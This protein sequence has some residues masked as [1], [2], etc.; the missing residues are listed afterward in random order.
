MGKTQLNFLQQN[1]ESFSS[2]SLTG[3]SVSMRKLISKAFH[4]RYPIC[5]LNFCPSTQSYLW[6]CPFLLQPIASLSV[7]IPSTAEGF[8]SS[9]QAPT[10]LIPF[11]RVNFLCPS[12]F[13]HSD[14]CIKKPS[15]AKRMSLCLGILMDCPHSPG[16][17]G[18]L[19]SVQKPRHLICSFVFCFVVFASLLPFVPLS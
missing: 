12:F 4:G 16:S 18:N 6:S 19:C 7:Q 5:F 10:A 14:K 11:L 3:V 13:T 1:P 2:P 17:C 15:N 9:P 8:W